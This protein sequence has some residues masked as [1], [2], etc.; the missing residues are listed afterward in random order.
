MSIVLFALK[1]K[2]ITFMLLNNNLLVY[3]KKILYNL[4][5]KK[6]KIHKL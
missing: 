4:F 3:H 1:Y 2:N 5:F 6:R